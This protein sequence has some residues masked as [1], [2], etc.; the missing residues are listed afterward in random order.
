MLDSE[1]ADLMAKYVAG[2]EKV[3]ALNDKQGQ[4]DY[5]KFQADLIKQVNDTFSAAGA[6]TVLAGRHRD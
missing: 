6:K 4:L 2:A 3:Q 1:R 5:L